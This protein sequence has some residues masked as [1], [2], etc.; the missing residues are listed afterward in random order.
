MNKYTVCRL[1]EVQYSA[2]VEA[3]SITEALLKAEELDGGEW[4]W[5]QDNDCDHFVAAV[6]GE[7]LEHE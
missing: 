2:D 6:N 5:D 7:E 4:S 3:D 1:V